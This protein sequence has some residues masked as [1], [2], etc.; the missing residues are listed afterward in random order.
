[1]RWL[2]LVVLVAGAFAPA[3]A[4]KKKTPKPPDVEVT[5]AMAQR[6]EGRVSIDVRLRNCSPKPIRKLVLLFDFLDPG[7]KV[8]STKKGEIDQEILAPGEDVEFH[9]QVEDNSRAVA[10]RARFEDAEERD[11]R[12]AKDITVT[13]D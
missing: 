11:L 2:L 6:Q 7:N 12:A 10:I 9:G 13:I 5:E 8:V 3:D 4:Q 1:M